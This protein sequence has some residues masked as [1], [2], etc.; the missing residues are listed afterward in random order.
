MAQTGLK[1]HVDDQPGDQSTMHGAHIANGV[2]H[3]VR[4]RCDL[5]LPGDCSHAV[6][7]TAAPAFGKSVFAPVSA[8]SLNRS[9]ERSRENNPVLNHRNKDTKPE[10]HLR[11]F[12]FCGESTK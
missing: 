7:R 6:Q 4:T 3:A 5:N 9:E 2:P 12:V 1:F 10:L 8:G 11:V